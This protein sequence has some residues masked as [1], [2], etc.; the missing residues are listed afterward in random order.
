MQSVGLEMRNVFPMM[1]GTQLNVCAGRCGR[2]EWVIGGVGAASDVRRS[3]AVHPF[4]GMSQRSTCWRSAIDAAAPRRSG[5]G[6]RRVLATDEGTWSR[7]C[8]PA[9]QWDGRPCDYRCLTSATLLWHGE[10]FST[11]ENPQ[12]KRKVKLVEIQMVREIEMLGK[13]DVVR[14]VEP[15]GTAGHLWC[16][17]ELENLEIVSESETE[18]GMTWSCLVTGNRRLMNKAAEFSN[19]RFVVKHNT[20]TSGWILQMTMWT[21]FSSLSSCLSAAVCRLCFCLV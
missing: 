4:T 10:W 14:K 8:S 15:P 3:A 12:V 6:R 2:A 5:L 21:G 16:N 7:R 13:W 1:W 11:R 18:S 9:S 17:P 19:M 20:Q